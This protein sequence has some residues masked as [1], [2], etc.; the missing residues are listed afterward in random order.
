MY[1]N[2]RNIR[3]LKKPVK[4]VLQSTVPLLG[5]KVANKITLYG[6]FEHG[7]NLANCGGWGL[8]QHRPEDSVALFWLY[9]PFR[10]R[11]FRSIAAGDIEGLLDL[12]NEPLAFTDE[13]FK[14]V[15][16]VKT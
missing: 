2:Y 11:K 4:A 15:E 9:K 12:N 8:Y 13:D 10:K 14:E 3:L 16:N 1:N 6:K 7:F 5:T